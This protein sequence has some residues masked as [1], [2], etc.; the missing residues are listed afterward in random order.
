MSSGQPAD[1]SVREELLVADPA[2]PPTASLRQSRSASGGTRGSLDGAPLLTPGGAPLRFRYVVRRAE[3]FDVIFWPDGSR[4]V[5]EEVSVA[6][7]GFWAEALIVNRDGARL[8][9]PLADVRQI[10]SVRQLL[11]ASLPSS[12]WLERQPAS[13]AAVFF[14]LDRTLLASSSSLVLGILRR[15]GARRR[16]VR[17]RLGRA[18]LALGRRETDVERLVADELAAT[19]GLRP[20]E[21]TALLEELLEASPNPLGDL[22]PLEIAVRHTAR[23]EAAY[24]VSANLQELAD[25]LAARLGLDAALGTVVE[26]DATGAYTGKP[27]RT[28]TGGAKTDALRELA[29]RDRLDLSASTFY[30][31]SA[32][33]LD[34]LEV[35]GHPVAVNPDRALRRAALAHGWPLLEI[36][37]K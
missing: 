8:R 10:D 19:K 15:R 24:L 31:D 29:D 17:A 26:L 32:F 22:Q 9:L 21:V 28:L 6:P 34:L 25:V 27:G 7:Y 11:F 30:S 20:E 12:A 3:G 36:R 23:A 2:R 13:R 14:D 33:D 16:V 37:P 5:V 1:A 4:G 18:R 35:V